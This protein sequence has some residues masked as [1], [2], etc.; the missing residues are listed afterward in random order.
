MEESPSFS[1]HPEGF[2][3]R[4][5]SRV[6]YC[7][8]KRSLSQLLRWSLSVGSTSQWD[9]DTP[10]AADL[11]QQLCMNSSRTNLLKCS[12]DTTGAG[13]ETNWRKEPCLCRHCCCICLGWRSCT[14][15]YALLHWLMGICGC[16]LRAQIM[17][18]SD[19]QGQVSRDEGISDWRGMQA[20][21]GCDGRCVIL[22]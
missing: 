5:Q 10:K 20:P 7:S 21:I 17:L 6:T 13:R 3:Y 2:D 15:L 19:T 14:D 11:P 4:E 9:S 8:A 18:D 12:F 22:P 16:P 1:R